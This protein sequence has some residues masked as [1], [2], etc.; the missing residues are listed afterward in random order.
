MKRW[1]GGDDL[2]V[3]AIEIG[4]TVKL[5]VGGCDGCEAGGGNSGLPTSDVSAGDQSEYLEPGGGSGSGRGGGA[6][7]VRVKNL[8]CPRIRS[9]HGI[10]PHPESRAG[11]AAGRLVWRT[12]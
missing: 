7:V 10:S 5:L 3:G 12:S 2:G 4:A 6:A 8:D 1:G 9:P 11:P